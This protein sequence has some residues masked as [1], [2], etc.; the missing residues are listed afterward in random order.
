MPVATAFSLSRGAAFPSR[1]DLAVLATG[2]TEPLFDADIRARVGD[3]R[4]ALAGQRVLVIGGAGSIGAATVAE[5]S[6]F[7][8]AALHV[9][10]VSE[11][12]LT[13]LVRDLRGRPS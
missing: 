4:D 1:E 2:R 12:G 3:L 5:L 11:N 10:D 13:E 8:V 9:I 7:D 6:R